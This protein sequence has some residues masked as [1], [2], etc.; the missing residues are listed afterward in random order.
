M[1]FGAWRFKSSHPHSETA[2]SSSSRRCAVAVLLRRRPRRRR[3]RPMTE[4]VV[5]LKAPPLSAF[6][7]SL[8]SARHTPVRARARRR[9]E[10]RDA[11]RARGDPGRADRLA[12]PHRRRRLRGRA[13]EEGRAGARARRRRRQGVAERHLPRA[14][15]TPSPETIDADKLWGTGLATSGQG[16][17]IG[18]IDDGIDAAHRYF[19]PAGFTYPPGFPKGQ[20]RFTTPKVIVARAFP[21]PGATYKYAGAAVRPEGVVPR[22]ARRRDRGRRPRRRRTGRCR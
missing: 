22:H 2:R 3:R 18:I 9:P 20:T 19:D 13:P 10:P 12:L 7:R 16:M 5:T 14:R 1:P 8:V 11:E 15:R 17:K 6:G 21:P 4:V